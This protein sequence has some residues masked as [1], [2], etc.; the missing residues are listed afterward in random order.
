MLPHIIHRPLAAM[1]R[2]PAG[3]AAKCFFQRNW[4]DTLPDPIDKVN[5]G[6]GKK[7][8]DHVAIQDLSGLS[9]RWCK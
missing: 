2:C 9:F 6:A 4:S 7:K 1:V 8:E 5:V 3:Q